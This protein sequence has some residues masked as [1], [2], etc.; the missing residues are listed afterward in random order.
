[1]FNTKTMKTEDVKAL[2]E[3]ETGDIVISKV[4][5][6]TY[7]VTAHYGNRVVAVRSADITNPI[8]WTVIRKETTTPQIQ[9]PPP[10]LPNE[11]QG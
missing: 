4:S 6:L 11:Q 9:I 8:E 1:M 2:S 5:K 3:L 7:V 10:E